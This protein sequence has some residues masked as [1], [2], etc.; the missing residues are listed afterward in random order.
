MFISIVTIDM[1][2]ITNFK[3]LSIYKY[4]CM[5]IM[6]TII[7]ITSVLQ[8]IIDIIINCNTYAYS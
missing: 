7:S 4:S 8:L 5:S 3:F 2:M 6:S 1:V